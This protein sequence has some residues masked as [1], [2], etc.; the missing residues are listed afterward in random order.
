MSAYD[1]DAAYLALLAPWRSGRLPQTPS[2]GESWAALPAREASTSQATG[3]RWI[4]RHGNAVAGWRRRSRSRNT[5]GD[6]VSYAG[7]D[8]LER[9]CEELSRAPEEEAARMQ[10]RVQMVSS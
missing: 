8:K 7:A 10:R 1:H 9:V 4:G 5:P 3:R 6:E 2:C